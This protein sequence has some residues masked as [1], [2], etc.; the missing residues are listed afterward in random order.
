MA[1][2][3]YAVPEN[4]RIEIRNCHN[5]VTVNGGE[6]ARTVVANGSARQDGDTLVFEN[7]N[8]VLVRVPR[9]ATVCITDCDADVRVDDLAGRVEIVRVDGDLA[10]RNLRGE[11]VVG[12]VDGDLAIKNVSTLQGQGVWNGDV[13]IRETSI[14]KLETLDGDLSVWGNRE[15]LVVKEI[16]GDVNLREM[17]GRVIIN[18]IGGDLIASEFKGGLEVADIRGDAIVSLVQAAE[19]KMV[20]KGDI[21]LRLP[22]NI[23][24]DIELDA[25]HGDLIARHDIQV[26]EEDEQHLRGT[27]GNGG[28]KIQV[29]ST[30]G[31]LILEGQQP[32]RHL[33][34]ARMGQEIAEQVHASLGDVPRGHVIAEQ[35][36]ESVRASL[37]DWK[38]HG[39]HRVIIRKH[40]HPDEDETTFEEPIEETPPKPTLTSAERQA[41][42]DAIARGELSV[43]DAIKK[44]R[45]EM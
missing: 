4:V 14:A 39:R 23:D 3:T 30:H 10:L 8:K 33:H 31:D 15:L 19:V 26:I 7:M 22:E 6:D 20:A 41:I 1:Q 42:L 38:R 25:P 12:Q 35:V 29:E 44:L 16:D 40:P 32:M 43:D 21:V 45:G 36:R 2:Q 37:G 24:A 11:T 27:I 5:R 17:N 13:A 9:T 18:H 34:F 28:I